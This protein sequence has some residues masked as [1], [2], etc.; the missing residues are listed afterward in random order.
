[1]QY[2]YIIMVIFSLPILMIIKSDCFLLD[3]V[4]HQLRG[5]ANHMSALSQSVYLHVFVFLRQSL[6]SVLV[7]PV[8]VPSKI[9]T[10]WFCYI[11]A[12]VLGDLLD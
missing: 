6:S 3:Y 10:N 11:K 12:D 2:I 7:S 5:Q 8:L 1:M 9:Y 4:L